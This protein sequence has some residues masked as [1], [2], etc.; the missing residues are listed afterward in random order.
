[1]CY[2]EKQRQQD[3]YAMKF[4]KDI[5]GSKATEAFKL[6]KRG[7]DAYQAATQTTIDPNRLIEAAAYF[8]AENKLHTATFEEEAGSIEDKAVAVIEHLEKAHGKSAI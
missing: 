1:M 6:V 7:V 5:F 8:V 2:I 3:D 4:C